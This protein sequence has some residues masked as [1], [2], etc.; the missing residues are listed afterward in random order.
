MILLVFSVFQMKMD[1]TV[2]SL[3]YISDFTASH[4]AEDTMTLPTELDED[5]MKLDKRVNISLYSLV[6]STSLSL[7]VSLTHP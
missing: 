2:F 5:M 7:T 3:K 6:L 1:I 4:H